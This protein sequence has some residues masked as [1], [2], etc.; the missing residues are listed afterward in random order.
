VA[1]LQSQ[2]GLRAE[3]AAATRVGI[4]LTEWSAWSDDDR[5]WVLAL[6]EWEAGR[7]PGCN[8]WLTETT[9]PGNEGRYRAEP[10]VRCF[11]CS[12][13]HSQQEQYKD[14]PNRAAQVLWPVKLRRRRRG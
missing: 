8:G 2:P 11:R 14:H 6:A 7:C 1:R 4:S 10:P 3:V 5:G 13:M 12:A 9:D